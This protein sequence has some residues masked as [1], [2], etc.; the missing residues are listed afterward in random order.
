MQTEFVVDWIII[1]DKSESIMD[2]FICWK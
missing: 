2:H 1:N